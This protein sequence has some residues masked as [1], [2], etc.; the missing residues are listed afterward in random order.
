MSSK[1]IVRVK[2]KM[3][4]L[5]L[6]P[7]TMF[8]VWMYLIQNLSNLPIFSFFNYTTY[9]C[10]DNK[11]LNPLVVIKRRLMQEHKMALQFELMNIK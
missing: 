9:G 4:N 3:T 1:M 7:T 5:G 6:K 10:S 11:S 8:L 2:W